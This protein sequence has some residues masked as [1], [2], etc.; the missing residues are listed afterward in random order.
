MTLPEDPQLRQLL[1]SAANATSTPVGLAERLIEAAQTDVP[2]RPARRFV[3]P[4]L[5][6]AAVLVLAAGIAVVADSHHHHAPAVNIPT[7]SASTPAPTPTVSV[8]HFSTT[9]VYFVDGQ[10]GWALG[11]GPCPTGVK[12]DCATL[13]SSNDG[14]ATWTRAGLPSGLVSTKDDASCGDNGGIAGPCIDQIAFANEHVGY[15]WSFHTLYMTTDGAH[16]WTALKS[17]QVVNVAFVGTTALRLRA[18]H[19]CSSPCDYELAEAQLGTNAWHVVTPGLPGPSNGTEITATTGRAYFVSGAFRFTSSDI[20]PTPQYLYTSTD[21]KHWTKARAAAL[22]GGESFVQVTAGPTGLLTL[23]C[24]GPTSESLPTVEVSTDHG[25]SFSTP[26]PLPKG[27]GSLIPDV[28][29]IGPG[30]LIGSLDT[31][32]GGT[33]RTGDGGR[34]WD[35]VDRTTL[36]EFGGSIAQFVSADEGFRAASDGSFVSITTD[37]G[38][39]WHHVTP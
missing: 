19:P 34:T 21:G 29:A 16:T 4:L 20:V 26:I 31:Q 28:V 24:P 5:A 6:A 38:V 35:L 1:D 11:D 33:Y 10:H 8:P 36:T 3:A 39:S 9:S 15:A 25:A 18:I 32:T 23:L 17:E 13:L 12:T 22:C 27:S 30:E 7:P 37:G 14:G 2:A